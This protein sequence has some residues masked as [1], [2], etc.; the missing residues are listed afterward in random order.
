MVKPSRILDK[1]GTNYKLLIAILLLATGYTLMTSIPANSQT[2]PELLVTW[3]SNDYVPA[4]YQGK[5]L[6]APGSTVNLALELIDNGKI[7]D[8]S[9]NEIRW[10]VD[11]KLGGSKLGMKNFSFTVGEFD[12]DDKNIM[13]TVLNYRGQTLE[14]LLTIPLADPEIAI[15]RLNSDNFQAKPYFFN[16]IALNQLSFRWLANNQS[17][18][19]FAENPDILELDLSQAPIGSP[20]NLSVDIFNKSN[21]LERA[22]G[23]LNF[24]L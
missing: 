13:I 24:S 11:A 12:R 6:P 7:A 10:S 5:I 1:I 14:K 16:I 3:K 21:P 18:K 4:D 8:L 15:Q 20:I 22:S 9:Q 2:I 19:G 17:P 23:L